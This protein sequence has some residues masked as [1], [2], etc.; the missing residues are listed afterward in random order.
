VVFYRGGTTGL[1]SSKKGM[2]MR[3]GRLAIAT[4]AMTAL[5][6]WGL[7]RAA[8]EAI[9][10][11][12]DPGPG[13]IEMLSPQDE[14]KTIHLPEG[15]HLE[16]VASEPDVISPVL[17]QWDGDGRMYVAEMR[18]YMLN[19]DGKDAHNPVSRVSRWESTRNDGVYDKHTVY[20]DHLMLPRMVLPLDDRVWI[21]E[22]DTKD[23][24]SYRDTK[25]DGVADEIVK[26]YDGG[27]QEGNLEHQPSGLLWDIDNWIYVTAQGERFRYTHGKVEK[28]PVKTAP[29]QWGIG[30]TDTG[31][32]IYGSA[33]WENGAHNFQVMPSYGNISLPGEQAG[34]FSAVYPIE[35]LTDVEG[36]VGRL[37]PGG[38]LNHITGCAGCSVYSGD[39]L[40][41]DLYGDYIL[42]E[43]VGRLIRRGKLTVVDGKNVVTNAYDHSEFIASTD[44]NFRPVWSA[45]GPDGC[46]YFCD[47]YHG[48]IQEANWTKEG[49]YL[50]PQIQK[51]GLDKNIKHGR[52]WRLVH[53]GIKPR[54]MPHM[55]EESTQQLVVHL[56][57][58]NGWW[59]DTAQKLIVL[60]Q[61]KSVVPALTTMAESDANPLAR[62]HAL[63]T[64][65]GLDSSA[66]SIV[67]D[68]LKDAD[69]NV[70]AAA[71]RIAE[72]RLKS[73][74][75][76]A[77]AVKST[78]GDS[79][80]S[81][82]KQLVLTLL[83]TEIPGA[84][85][86]IKTATSKHPVAAQVVQIYK[87]NIAKALEEQRKAAEMA[88]ADAAKG[89]L[90]VHGRDIYKQTCIACHGADGNG[91]PVP[92]HPG[93]TLAPPLKGSRKLL[94]DRQLVARVVLHGLTGPDDGKDF[95]GQMAGF[96]WADDTFIASALTYARNDFGN[97]ASAIKPEDVALVR[98]MTA[99][100][101]GPFTQAELYAAVQSTA[102]V[103]AISSA[104]KPDP[105]DLIFD[106]TT[107]EL[108][109][110]GI[111]VE[112]YAGGLDVGYWNLPDDWVSWPA[113]PIPGGDYSVV[114]RYATADHSQKAVVM[115]GS[116][117]YPVAVAKTGGWES[118]K[119]T[120]VGTVHF[121]A[122]TSAVVSFKPDKSQSWGSMNLASVRLVPGVARK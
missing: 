90:F 119:D 18:S 58:H 100:R 42:P 81:V 117:S 23:I 26:V 7:S 113:Q 44:P 70:R 57:D 80:G 56:S 29:G 40:P 63:W 102:P 74:T 31:Q 22:T 101:K 85:A 14:L 10:G 103:T 4:A 109:G 39:A 77:D 5:A 47:M 62:L 19:I 65:D 54:A 50:R 13:Q 27:K 49:S 11:A 94:A 111:R 112:C 59:R 69:G 115:V 97:N 41:S 106:C 107:V 33:S 12:P 110:E 43:P 36:G 30:Q 38:G 17:C 114:V 67:I 48:I 9:P 87:D 120:T 32:L 1:D 84:D 16:L 118:F 37:R 20:A 96:P 75:V 73:D 53:D 79:D 64:L 116:Q 55:I 60:R 25:H 45:T 92:G 121:D 24:V 108:H 98:K 28:Q 122:P 86:A 61:D 72:P 95:P 71:I 8:N 21:R 91:A 2:R 82:A 104:I 52:I 6:A 105:G 51:Y 35:H 78:A 34:D 99:D 68:K 15:Y 66:D 3:L 93:Q 76:L 83:T 46:L 89:E 88:R